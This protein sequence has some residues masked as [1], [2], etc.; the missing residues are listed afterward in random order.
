MRI[1]PKYKIARRLGDSIFEKTR[2]QRYALVE[3]K[4]KANIQKRK[5]HRSNFTEYGIQFLEK[6]KIRFSYGITERQLANYVAKA[7]T[8]RKGSPTEETFRMLELRL[9]NVL[10]RL[11]IAPTRQFGRKGINHGHVTINGQKMDVASYQVKIGE[12]V[13]VKAK[14]KEGGLVRGRKEALKEYST[15]SWLLLD[16]ETLTGTVKSLPKMGEHESNLNFGL[17]VQFYSRV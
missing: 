4:K 11:G 1:G 7:K 3:G 8:S 12:I 10:Y 15:P 5:K 17:V 16:P 14:S 13:G 6:Q 9:D 2:T